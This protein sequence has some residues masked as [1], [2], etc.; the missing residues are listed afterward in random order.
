MSKPKLTPCILCEKKIEY[1][2]LNQENSFNLDFAC[3][4]RIEGHYGTI[5]DADIY[6]AVICDDCVTILKNKELLT[7]EGNYLF[8]QE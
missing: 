2:D 5:H 8:D 7:Y 6:T 4:V 3:S 1:L